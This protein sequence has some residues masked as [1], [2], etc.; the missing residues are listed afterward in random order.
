VGVRFRVPLLLV[1]ILAGLIAALYLSARFVLERSFTALEQ[2]LV[3]RNVVRAAGALAETVEALDTRCVDWAAWDETYEFVV[4]RNQEY[5][6]TNLV[7]T[8]FVNQRFNLMVFTDTRGRVVFAKAF[9]LAA[10]V[11]APLPP[12]LRAHLV[13][14]ALVFPEQADQHSRVAGLLVLPEGPLLVAARPILT[15]EY[16]GPVRG[17]LIVGRFLDAEETARLAAVTR[18]SLEFRRPD[19]PGLPADL[20]EAA[21]A[22][23]PGQRLVRPLDRYRVAGYALLEDVY[24]RPALLLRVEQSRDVYYRKDE[25]LRYLG[26]SLLAVALAAGVMTV[27]LLERMVLFP[28]VRLDRE[29]NRVGATGDVRARVVPPVRRGELA[30]LAAGIN[31]MLEALDESQRRLQ[32]SEELFRTLA[33]HAPIGIYIVQGGRFCFVNP[34]FERYTGYNAEELLGRNSLDL[35]LPEDRETVRRAAAAMLKGKRSAPYEFRVLTKS[36]EVRWV[37]EGV[38]SIRYGGARAA[39]GSYM[40]VTEQK[41]TEE[42]LRRSEREKAAILDAM[43]ELVVYHDAEMRILWANRAA[44]ASLGLTAEELV[45][46]HC[47]ELWHGLDRPCEGCPV[48]R[49]LRLGQPQEGEAKTPD[50]RYWF[51]RGYPV[52]DEA[53]RVTGAVEVTLEITERRRLEEELR[54]LSFHD[55]LTGLYNR[56]YFEQEMRRLED[57]RHA[58][59][60]VVMWD[61][62]GLKL[63]NDVLGHEAGD[64]LLVAAATVTKRCFRAGDVVARIGGDEFA[65][66]LPRAPQ[67]VAEEVGRRIRAAVA[68]YNAAG[69]AVPLSVSVGCATGGGARP[70]PDV[71]READYN[72]Y[73]EKLSSNH[74]ARELIVQTIVRA[75]EEQDPVAAARGQRVRELAAAL[76]AAAGLPEKQ[77]AA[78]ELL[79]RYHDIGKAGLPEHIRSRPE[80]LLTPEERRELERHPENGYRIAL[81]VPG[82]API[83]DLILKHREW[84]NG[85]GYPLGLK[86]EEIPLECR[87]LAVAEAYAA[88]VAEPPAGEGLGPREAALRLREYAGTRLD[89]HLVALFLERVVGEDAA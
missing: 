54:F 15:S 50:G 63:V 48:E 60:S 17:T 85:Q 75:L 49:A 8:T 39:L 22:L 4:D 70:L 10:G 51:V 74:G 21:A 11:A 16:G 47:Y 53:G 83:A 30:N 79:A 52:R 3:D 45:G 72:M 5:I 84:W 44:A 6:R 31:R 62:D 46:R 34:Q 29:V 41:R 69:P 24:S 26:L 86:G 82:L 19:D 78:L 36:G 81:V 14:G 23:A 56:A 2:E 67:A 27:L 12:G 89:P 66:L 68:E 59:V 28:L 1:L 20:R 87:V 77:A 18:L 65:A 80:A 42:A 55:A 73:R 32:E 64:R 37:M 9:D 57:G 61:V 43:S 7:D 35:V 13:P 33:H 58:P 71:L 40:D 88:L 38:A 25:A 76:A